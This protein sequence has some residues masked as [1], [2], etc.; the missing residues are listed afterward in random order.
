MKS[1]PG[2]NFLS[3]QCK[4]SHPYP[5]PLY[6]Y[7]CIFTRGQLRL[8]WLGNIP[9]EWMGKSHLPPCIKSGRG[10]LFNMSKMH[11]KSLYVIFKAPPLECNYG[12]I[13][14]RVEILRPHPP[15]IFTLHCKDRK[16]SPGFDSIPKGDGVLKTLFFNWDVLAKSQFQRGSTVHCIPMGNRD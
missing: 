6:L 1:K 14:L 9:F 2:E 10:K 16:F 13:S 8:L 7:R 3:L 5:L 4:D 11:C 15:S 12:L